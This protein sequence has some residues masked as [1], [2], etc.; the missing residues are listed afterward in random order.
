MKNLFTLVTLAFAGSAFSFTLD[1]I[2]LWSGTGA[3]RAALVI[4][5]SEAGVPAFAWGHRFD[6]SITGLA[7]AE[8]VD[9]ADA[10]LSMTTQDFGSFGIAITG[11]AY[12]SPF[13]NLSRSGFSNGS[14]LSYWLVDDSVSASSWI[15]SNVGASSRL[16]NG[17]DWDGWKWGNGSVSPSS[18]IVAAVPEP[19]TVLALA[20]GC[21]ALLR[22]RKK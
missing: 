5:F 11:F 3:N 16:I 22:R 1:D 18:N 2:K 8:A 10:N 13:G 17:D 20:S 12:T 19:M 4:D 6:G 7:L 14:Y 21:V 9:A 15:S